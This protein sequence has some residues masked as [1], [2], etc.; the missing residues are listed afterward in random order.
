MSL[1][2]VW[3]GAL[4]VITDVLSGSEELGVAIRVDAFTFL[5]AQHYFKGGWL[6]HIGLVTCGAPG[7][8]RP[9]FWETPATTLLIGQPF[10]ANQRWPISYGLGYRLWGRKELAAV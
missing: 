2:V 10:R 7:L 3:L 1:S 9:I 6:W 5:G 8:A 4:S